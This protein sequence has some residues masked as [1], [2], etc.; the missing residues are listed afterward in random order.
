MDGI[1]KRRGFCSKKRSL[2]FRPSLAALVTCI[3]VFSLTF[4]LVQADQMNGVVT[5]PVPAPTPVLPSNGG[6][7][8]SLTP[9][10]TWENTRPADSFEIQVDDDS[11]FSSPAIDTTVTSNWYS[12]STLLADGTGYY[13]RLRMS[14][15][16]VSSD[17]SSTRSFNV[18]ENILSTLENQMEALGISSEGKSQ[19]LENAILNDKIALYL[20]IQSI[21]GAVESSKELEQGVDTDF[22][23]TAGEKVEITITSAD[24]NGKTIIVNVDNT[25]IPT[26]S[27]SGIMVL[28]DGAS[29]QLANNY[30]DVLNPSDESTP[31]YLVVLGETGAQVLVSIPEFSTHTIVIT[32]ALPNSMLTY[33]AVG[34]VLA[35]VLLVVGWR[36]LLRRKVRESPAPP[37]PLFPEQPHSAPPS[38]KSQ[39]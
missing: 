12:P 23:V 30:G 1:M 21:G 14:R 11:S 37:P 28:Y 24:E 34:G 35:V 31:E 36:L 2:E 20:N 32:N 18:N 27:A 25:T 19:L 10:F 13:W 15:T 3:L 16:G 5:A 38:Q 33:I 17:W 4:S 29:I 7:S 6:T 8:T 22:E 9:T 26:S 39:V